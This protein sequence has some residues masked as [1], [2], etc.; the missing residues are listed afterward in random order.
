MKRVCEQPK[1]LEF[2]KNR[3]MLDIFQES[4]QKLEL[5]QKGL[6]SYLEGKRLSF[7]RFFFLSNEELL[8][9]LSETKDPE[10]VQPHLKK[11]FEGIQKLKIDDDNKIRGMFSS[12]GEYVAFISVVD[13]TAARGNVD[14]WLLKVESSMLE[15]VRK[16]VDVAHE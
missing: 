10:R 14:E 16:T 2:T 8:E 13:T 5:V 3:K 12:E 1:V 4:V 9:I 7:P 15:A 6:N 11:C